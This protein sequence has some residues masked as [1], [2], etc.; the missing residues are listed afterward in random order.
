MDQTTSDKT[1]KLLTVKLGHV[2]A[3]EVTF[4]DLLKKGTLQTK[5]NF[6]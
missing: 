5:H 2:N 3:S 4:L 1:Y 6:Y